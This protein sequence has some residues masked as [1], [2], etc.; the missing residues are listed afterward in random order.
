M[1]I[2]PALFILGP[3][4]PPAGAARAV[5]PFAEVLGETAF[6]S[7]AAGVEGQLTGAMDQGAASAPAI[8]PSPPKT[9]SDG[10]DA[11]AKGQPANAF[12]FGAFGIFAPRREGEDADA[13][14]LA[15]G[16]A[17]AADPALPQEADPVTGVALRALD[18]AI[19]SAPAQAANVRSPG[20]ER[21]AGPG[22]AH[23][24]TSGRPV[25]S[26]AAAAAAEPEAEEQPVAG[27]APQTPVATPRRIAAPSL[28]VVE[29][30]GA[31]S[32]VAAAPNFEPA[33][34]AEARVRLAAAAA[35][36]GV[37]LDELQINGHAGVAPVRGGP[38][39][40]HRAR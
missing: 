35:D 30:D 15:S 39:H 37:S 21:V 13:A 38:R 25:A 20:H 32:V 1:R 31:V 24:A 33:D 40:G 6:A 23:T 2:D 19:G 9:A 3:S 4:A 22:A 10:G 18:L 27:A 34:E 14:P 8:L 29:H 5:T 11:E 26:V 7:L 28:T 16:K 12:A 36:L 17:A